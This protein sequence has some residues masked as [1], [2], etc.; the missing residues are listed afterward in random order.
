M[1]SAWA[2]LAACYQALPRREWR[3]ALGSTAGRPLYFL[4]AVDRKSNNYQGISSATA[5]P[6]SGSDKGSTNKKKQTKKETTSKNHLDTEPG[7]DKKVMTAQTGFIMEQA[8]AD[9][10]HAMLAFLEAQTELF[11]TPISE[12]ERSVSQPRISTSFY[13]MTNDERP[14]K[15]IPSNII[16]ELTVGQLTILMTLVPT[17][18]VAARILIRVV[19]MS[20]LVGPD[21]AVDAAG[22][23]R[24]VA[25]GQR[26]RDLYQEQAIPRNGSRLGVAA[27]AA[28]ALAESL[29]QPHVGYDLAIA[30]RGAGTQQATAN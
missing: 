21:A 27:F 7:P 8:D 14:G 15:E 6:A 2:V 12:S 25:M 16:G 10:L 9:V 20:G 28:Q 30:A 4:P 29:R 11:T 5:T 26:D 19:R 18:P 24:A 17:Y 1:A 13:R 3:A 23:V 22:W